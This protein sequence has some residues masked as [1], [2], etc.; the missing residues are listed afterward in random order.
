M[1]VCS[2]T[3]VGGARFS[4]GGSRR[5]LIRSYEDRRRAVRHPRIRAS[6]RSANERARGR[7]RACDRVCAR[8]QV[9]ARL[10]VQVSLRW[11]TN[12]LARA[13][14]AHK[15]AQGRGER[16]QRSHFY[17]CAYPCADASACVSHDIVFL[18]V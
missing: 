3:R 11:H 13:Q 14:R 9:R 15:H 1:R 12:T 16:A 10:Y 5:R 6:Q 4:P 7:E 8:V 2:S 18:L 17:A